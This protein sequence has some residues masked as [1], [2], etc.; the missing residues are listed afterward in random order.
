MRRPSRE[1]AVAAVVLDRPDPVDVGGK[2]TE[3]E[4]EALGRGAGRQVE[5]A[6]GLARTS[7]IGGV[8]ADLECR[9]QSPG[10]ISAPAIEDR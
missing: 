3:L 6:L 10:A 5:Q 7:G 9:P 8:P 1:S 2:G 4:R